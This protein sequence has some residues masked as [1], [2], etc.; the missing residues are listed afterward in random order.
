MVLSSHVRHVLIVSIMS[1]YRIN[2]IEVN[3]SSYHLIKVNNKRTRQNANGL[4]NAIYTNTILD[5]K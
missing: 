2:I 4:D 5:S 1:V 3:E